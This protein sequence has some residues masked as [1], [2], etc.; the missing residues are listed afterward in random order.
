MKIQHAIEIR[1]SRKNV[2]AFLHHSDISKIEDLL[3]QGIIVKP[4][5]WLNLCNQV[6]DSYKEGKIKNRALSEIFQI[7]M[8]ENTA[9]RTETYRFENGNLFKY[10]ESQKAYVFL[11][12][13]SRKDFNMLYANTYID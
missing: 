5:V 11:K 9:I 10:D 12:P 4:V 13:C 1:N 7:L 8:T 6:M 3:G 2:M